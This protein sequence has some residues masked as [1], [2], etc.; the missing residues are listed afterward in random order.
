MN[1]FTSCRSSGSRCQTCDS[2]AGSVGREVQPR[3]DRVERRP[4][5]EIAG[6]DLQQ[7]RI[8]RHPQQRIVGRDAVGIRD[9]MQRG[10][11]SS[12]SLSLGAADEM[13]LFPRSRSPARIADCRRAASATRPLS[14]RNWSLGDITIPS[15]FSRCARAGTPSCT[16]CCRRRTQRPPAVADEPPEVVGRV[17][18]GQCAARIAPCECCDV[19]G[20]RQNGPML[21]SPRHRGGKHGK[22]REGSRQA[23]RECDAAQEEGDAEEQLRPQSEEP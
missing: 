19:H 4:H 16:D 1:A 18:F 15:L 2:S 10:T 17:R 8:E 20:E 14:D 23:G 7:F 22:V 11:S 13:P 5:A 12:A 9:E 21:A 3:A 6:D